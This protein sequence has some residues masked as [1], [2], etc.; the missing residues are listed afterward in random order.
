MM[1][2]MHG[3]RALLVVGSTLL[4]TVGIATSIDRVGPLRTG[5]LKIVD[6]SGRGRVSLDTRVVPR[7]DRLF[8]GLEIFNR[9]GRRVLG[10]AYESTGGTLGV[11]PGPQGFPTLVAGTAPGNA[12]FWTRDVR[13]PWFLGAGFDF[14]SHLV[15]KS[16]DREHELRLMVSEDSVG[17]VRA[18]IANDEPAV[19]AES[20]Q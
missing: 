1:A 9:N 3:V 17:F 19:D 7:G 13:S 2:L 14:T 16:E 6:G 4:V 18:D 10:L 8:T 5:E 12:A 11:W 15:L 20:R